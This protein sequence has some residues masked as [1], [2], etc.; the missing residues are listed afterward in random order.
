MEY[1]DSAWI[2][3]VPGWLFKKEFGSLQLKEWNYMEFITTVV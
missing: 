3:N 1:P 2:I